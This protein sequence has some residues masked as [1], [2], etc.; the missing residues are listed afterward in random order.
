MNHVK[1]TPGRWKVSEGEGMFEVMRVANDGGRYV[2]T[3]DNTGQ[4]DIEAKANAR[5]LATAPELLDELAAAHQI[6]KNALAIMTPEQKCQ[7]GELND[8][9]GVSGDGATRANERAAVIAKATGGA[10]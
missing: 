3:I 8:A 2:C 5:L 4:P 7:W 1:H 6:I 10:A 9:E